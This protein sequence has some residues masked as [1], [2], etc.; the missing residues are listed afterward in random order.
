MVKAF[1]YSNQNQRIAKLTT[2]LRPENDQDTDVVHDGGTS[3][4][5]NRKNMEQV[6]DKNYSWFAPV[7]DYRV[8]PMDPQTDIKLVR[9]SKL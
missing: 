6:W 2:A 1:G 3:I 9:S 7:M 4:E 8:S 5:D